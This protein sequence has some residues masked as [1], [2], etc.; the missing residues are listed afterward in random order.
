MHKQIEP[1]NKGRTPAR[2]ILWK[3]R[4][5]QGKCID[6]FRI[7]KSWK[8]FLQNISKFEFFQK[9]LGAKIQAFYVP[10]KS[11]GS[12]LKSVDLDILGCEIPQIL[13]EFVLD[14]LGKRFFQI[15]DVGLWISEILQKLEALWETSENGKFA[16][17]WILP[18]EEIEDCMVI[19]ATG[20]PVRIGHRDLVQIYNVD[21]TRLYRLIIN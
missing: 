21:K 7:L 11:N 3:I 18:E 9:Y 19:D 2:S 10:G 16:I 13:K 12:L 4:K 17:K 15:S 1:P 8:K 14:V 5:I 20:F 6:Y